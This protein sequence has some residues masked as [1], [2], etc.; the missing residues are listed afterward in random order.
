MLLFVT[1]EV[2]WRRTVNMT[3]SVQQLRMQRVTARLK[4]GQCCLV[5][6]EWRMLSNLLTVCGIKF[7][8]TFTVNLQYDWLVFSWFVWN[9]VWS[10][11]P[12][13]QSAKFGGAGL[14]EVIS[15]QQEEGEFLSSFWFL[16]FRN[17]KQLIDAFL[18]CEL[19]LE[20]YCI[21]I[22]SVISALVGFFFFFVTGVAKHSVKTNNENR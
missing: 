5:L 20:Y 14:G 2:L 16:M 18:L 21:F 13:S 7:A 1:L 12:C 19:P 6:S 17:T 3:L 8:V 9:T 15:W 10:C 22:A 11:A 4:L